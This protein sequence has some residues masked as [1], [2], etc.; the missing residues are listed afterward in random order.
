MAYLNIWRLRGNASYVRLEDELASG[1][2]GRREELNARMNFEVTKNWYLGAG[3]RE[4]LNAGTVQDQDPLSPTFGAQ[5]PRDGTIRQDFILGY[6]DECSLIELT[7]A[8]DR[9]QDQGLEPDN[10]FLIR[11]T[12]RS[13]VD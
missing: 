13:L 5:I 8:R 9:T 11:F 7:Y 12:L 10:A 1:T 3:W 2:Q 4:N 6:Q